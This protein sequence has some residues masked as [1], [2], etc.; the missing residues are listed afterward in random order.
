MHSEAEKSRQPPAATPKAAT[1]FSTIQIRQKALRH[2]ALLLFFKTQG[3]NSRGTAAQK[4]G[5]AFFSA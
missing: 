1:K 5:S 4:I 2:L 3:V